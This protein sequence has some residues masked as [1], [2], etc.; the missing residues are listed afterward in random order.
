MDASLIWLPERRT[1]RFLDSAASVA[2]AAAVLVLI[3]TAIATAAGFKLLID[4]S[5]S[6]QPAIAAGDLIMT[7]RV[8]PIE[9]EAGAIVT[10]RD[11]SRGSELV[12]HRVLKKRHQGGRVAFVT[13][14]DANTGVER[15]SIDADGTLGMLTWRIPKAG[16][17]ASWFRLPVVRFGFLALGTL[18]VGGVALRRIWT[19]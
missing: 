10:F 5:D 7:K 6:M 16:Y 13:R 19:H 14:G 12:T 2:C 3:A 11:P 17:A 18:L 9:V 15:W 8:R 4:R 1:R